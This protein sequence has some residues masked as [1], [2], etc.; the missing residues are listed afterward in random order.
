MLTRN[1][2]VWQLFQ[3]FSNNT[4]SLPLRQLIRVMPKHVDKYGCIM[5][6]RHWGEGVD[7][8]S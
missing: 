4:V 1:P 3:I 7:L 5:L 6:A 8:S 2:C